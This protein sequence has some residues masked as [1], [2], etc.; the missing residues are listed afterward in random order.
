[1]PDVTEVGI[2]ERYVAQPNRGEVGLVNFLRHQRM[3]F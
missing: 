1:L 3:V 2:V